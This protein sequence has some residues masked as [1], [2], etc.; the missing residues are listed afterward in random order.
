VALEVYIKGYLEVALKSPQ[1]LF[2]LNSLRSRDSSNSFR[3]PK[4]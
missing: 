2:H 3:E 4:S 1:A